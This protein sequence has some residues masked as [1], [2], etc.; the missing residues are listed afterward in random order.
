MLCLGTT[1]LEIKSG[2][3]LSTAEEVKLLRV[4]RDVAATAPQTIAPTLLAAHA[5]P[6]EYRED[7]EGYVAYVCEDTIPAVAGADLARFCDVFCERGAFAVAQSRRVLETGQRYG[8]APKLHAEQKSHLGGTALAAE[9]RATSVDHLEYAAEEDIEALA[10]GGTVAVLLPGA[11]FMLREPRDA[12]ARRLVELGVPVALA[13]DFNPGTSPI[14]SMPVLIG[15]AC[16]RLGLS[17]EEALVAAMINAAHAIGLADEV[18]SLEPGKLADLLVLDA[19]SYRHLPYYFAS[20]LVDTVVKRGRVVVE[21][22]QPVP[23]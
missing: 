8:L 13:T 19:P 2:Y 3:G 9:L 1:T 4:V 10:A 14:C 16:L 12:P 11:A 22:G 18:G 15:L 17:P 21:H 6:P 20:N 5:V 23:R 7:A